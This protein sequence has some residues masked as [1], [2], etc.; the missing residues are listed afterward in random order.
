M[1]N[2]GIGGQEVPKET[3]EGIAEIAQNKTLFVQKLTADPAVKPEVVGGLKTTEE[4]FAHYK[5]QLEVEFNKE[6]GSTSKENLSFSNVG[7]FGPKGIVGQSPFLQNLT[8]QKEQYLKM[9]KQLKTNKLLKT[10]S[11]DKEAKQAYI[12]ALQA[13]LQELEDNK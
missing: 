4:V 10:I 9:A 3:S 13:L 5:P 2:Y 12:N 1:M 8:N 11:E 6:D 7:D